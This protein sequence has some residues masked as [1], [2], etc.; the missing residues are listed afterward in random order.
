VNVT[1]QLLL[2]VIL[3]SMASPVLPQ[4]GAA[5]K[6]PQPV[7]RTVFMHRADNAFA[8]MDANKDGFADR[9]EIEAAETKAMA[10]RKAQ[11]VK[12]R[13]VAFRQLD[14]NKDGSLSLQEFNGAVSSATPKVDATPRLT[15]L[16]ANK[17]GKISITE[18]RAPFETQFVRLDANKDGILSVDEQRRPAPKAR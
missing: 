1:N 13:E 16:D 8:A 11:L 4:A 12:Q 5:P 10:A 3:A 9:A 15:R 6:G 7:S 18:S 17:D 14:K 2:S